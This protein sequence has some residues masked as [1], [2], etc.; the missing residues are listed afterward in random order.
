MK[1]ELFAAYG[2]LLSSLARLKIS[3]YEQR[4]IFQHIYIFNLLVK[5]TP[6]YTPKD[7]IIIASYGI[8]N[9][10]SEGYRSMNNTYDEGYGTTLATI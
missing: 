8:I 4:T 3:E 5:Q 1:V 9:F 6:T 7:H 2:R 10:N